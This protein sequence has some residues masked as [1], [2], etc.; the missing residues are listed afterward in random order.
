MAAGKLN[1]R[2]TLQRRSTSRDAAGQPLD[3]WQPV[4]S[5]WAD[6]KFLTGT[7]ATKADRETGMARV[8][9][10][11][12]LRTDVCTGMRAVKGSTVYDIKSALPQ[13]REWLDLVCEVPQ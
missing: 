8:S 10:R 12:R 7:A 3:S 5:V 11:I 4:A 2:I 1:T 9:V 13:G 6:I